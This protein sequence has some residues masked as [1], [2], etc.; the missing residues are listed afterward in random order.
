MIERSA[1]LVEEALRRH[2]SR[3][4]SQAHL[5]ALR[6]VAPEQLRQRDSLG[7]HLSVALSA[8]ALPG[9]QPLPLPSCRQL[10][11]FSN[12]ATATQHLAHEDGG[13]GIL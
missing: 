13:R 2:P 8:L 4:R 5:A 12:C 1:A 10:G 9:D 3:Y 7:P 6:L 11:D